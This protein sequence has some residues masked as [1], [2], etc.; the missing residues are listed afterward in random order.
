MPTTDKRKAQNRDS[1]RKHRLKVRNQKKQLSDENPVLPLPS[2]PAP[3]PPLPAP[4]PIAD[5]TA[6]S[7]LDFDLPLMDFVPMGEAQWPSDSTVTESLLGTFQP[8]QS[9]FGPPY[10]E[11]IPQAIFR[12]IESSKN[13]SQRRHEAELRRMTSLKIIRANDLERMRLE[14]QLRALQPSFDGSPRA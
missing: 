5:T 11:L 1:Q 4:L 13:N 14:S 6:N 7:T 10:I 8:D 2:L 9:L 3:P 12:L